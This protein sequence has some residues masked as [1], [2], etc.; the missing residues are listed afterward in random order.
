VAAQEWAAGDAALAQIRFW[1]AI[2]LSLGV[3]VL[4][5]SLLPWTA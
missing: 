2:N 1:L 3:V 4:L 5:V